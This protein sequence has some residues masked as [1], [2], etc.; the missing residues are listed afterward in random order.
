MP[1]VPRSLGHTFIPLT[2]RVLVVEMG[3]RMVVRSTRALAARLQQ[4]LQ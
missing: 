1:Q 2:M 3:S 4:R